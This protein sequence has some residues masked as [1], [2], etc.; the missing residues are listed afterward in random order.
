LPGTGSGFTDLAA[1]L[2]A[3]HHIGWLLVFVNIPTHP[4]TYFGA[5]RREASPLECFPQ[6]LGSLAFNVLTATTVYLDFR[7]KIT[8]RDVNYIR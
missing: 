6:E 1:R 3:E 4:S 7:E 8:W 2:Q 5:C